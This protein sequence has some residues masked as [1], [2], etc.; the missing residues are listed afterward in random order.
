VHKVGHANVGL[1]RTHV[2]EPKRVRGDDVNAVLDGHFDEAHA[3]GNVSVL[4]VRIG[5]RVR[6]LGEPAR[7]EARREALLAEDARD[8]PPARVRDAALEE[9]AVE[10]VPLHRRRDAHDQLEPIDEPQPVPRDQVPPALVEDAVRVRAQEVLSVWRKRLR[11]C[12][13]HSRLATRAALQ[14]QFTHERAPL[15]RAEPQRIVTRHAE[16]GLL[17]TPD[18]APE[19][20]WH[21]PEHASVVHR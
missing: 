3:V 18:Q 7:D 1:A 5:S 8:R 11:L 15:W 19:E 9:L 12:A 2:V 4:H 20:Q 10:R 16:E 21:V 17:W 6:G 13:H 14:K